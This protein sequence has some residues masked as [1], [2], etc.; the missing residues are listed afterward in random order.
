MNVKQNKEKF[1]YII[2]L[3]TNYISM[4]N[5]HDAEKVE[6]VKERIDKFTSADE[7]NEL[8]KKLS[9]I[10]TVYDNLHGNEKLKWQL[11]EKD[12][13]VEMNQLQQQINEIH[14]MIDLV[15]EFI[16]YNSKKEEYQINKKSRLYKYHQ[17]T[18]KTINRL[19]KKLDKEAI[20]VNK[21]NVPRKLR[22]SS[23]K[24]ANKISQFVSSL[25]RALKVTPDETSTDILI[26]RAYRYLI[27]ENIVKNGFVDE[28]GERWQYFTSSAG[29]IRNRKSLW[30]K[31]KVYDKVKNKLTC[32]LS[33]KSINEQGGM[34][35]NKWNAYTALCTTSS[36][37]WEGFEIEK[38]IVVPDFITT[39]QDADV[40]YIDDKTYKIEPRQMPIEIN[41]VDGAGMYLP[42]LDDY[43]SFQ[44]R[45][46]FFKGLMIPFSYD[47]F[48]ETFNGNP[49]IKDI[50]G[51]T[52]NVIEKG[53]KYIFTESQF[54]AHSYFK[55]WK[56]YQTNFVKYKCE[57]SKCKEESDTFEDKTLNYQVIQSLNNMTTPQLTSLASRTVNE[58]KGVGNDLEVMKRLIGADKDNERKN[59]FQKAVEI[60]PNLINDVYSREVIK[61][62]KRSLVKNARAGKLILDGTKRTYIAPDLFA[63]A[64][65]LFLGIEVP[66]GLLD[67]GEVSC[68]LYQDGEKL[69][70]LRSPHNFREHCVRVNKLDKFNDTDKDISKWFITNDLY[71]STKDLISKQLMFDVDGDDSMIVNN[72]QFVAIAEEHMRGIKPLQY[73]LAK[74]DKEEINNPN[75]YKALTAAYSKSQ[76]IGELANDICK[77]W[78]SGKVDKEELDLIRILCFESNAAIDYAKTLWY[79]TRLPEMNEKLKGISRQKVPFFFKNAKD[80]KNNQVQPIN[81][82]VVNQ[83]NEIIPNN[84]IVFEDVAGE[85]DYK[86]L[87]HNK[88]YELTEDDQEIIDLYIKENK[89]KTKLIK[90]QMK[91]QGNMKKKGI[92]LQ[93]Y[94]DIRDKFLKLGTSSHV[95][96]VLVKYL[97]EEQNDKH[98]QT[99]WFTFGWEIVRNLEWNINEIK[100]CRR[101]KCEIES[102]QAKQYCEECAAEKERERKREWKKNRKVA[103]IK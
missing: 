24:D 88:S 86:L 35:I 51:E 28:E 16:T 75:I 103:K 11:Q 94:K 89:D 93:V 10:R 98:K 37:V 81:K 96:D 43:K 67:N 15:N 52:H 30:I 40:D 20:K 31:K 92:E 58:I 12:K 6:K 63:F 68:Q 50:Y 3:A 95:T 84:N 7:L 25:T 101:C 13:L 70:C 32:G 1:K 41:H 100:R 38:A 78:N 99:L 55:D 21:S 9:Q 65:W 97:Y 39:I 80:K 33:I 18:S 27:F 57:A 59:P 85:F 102:K 87:M 76:L 91:N 64:E 47:S 62:K 42:D 36:T 54:K 4:Q 19:K 66:N 14:N 49:N 5:E 72:P 17:Y 53:I 71:T 90:K 23:L 60:Y 45:M 56:E 2:E 69:D 29:Q 26:V 79:P 77:I 22:K 61:E 82:S 83:L 8:N 48:L 44:F 73:K 74:A 34:N 46:P